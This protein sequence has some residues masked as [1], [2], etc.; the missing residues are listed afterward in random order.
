MIQGNSMQKAGASSLQDKIG[1]LA[2]AIPAG[3]N[4]GLTCSGITAIGIA[5]N[6][7]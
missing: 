5:K 7:W 6:T 2:A 1:L 3:A 4:V